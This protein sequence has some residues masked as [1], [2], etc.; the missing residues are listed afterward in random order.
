MPS[1]H[2]QFMWFF[3]LYL[4]LF[5]RFRLSYSGQTIWKV[6]PDNNN[7]V[8]LVVGYL[9]ELHVNFSEFSCYTGTVPYC[10][11]LVYGTVPTVLYSATTEYISV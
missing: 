2:S 6:G 7:K 11:P 9:P 5:I 10:I 1:N 8:L 3:C 4:V